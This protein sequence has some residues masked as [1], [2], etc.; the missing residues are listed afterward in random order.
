LVG[1]L[2]YGCP[3]IGTSSINWAQLSKLFTC[4]WKQ[5]L[6]RRVLIEIMTMDNVQEEVHF[7]NTPSSQSLRFK[8]IFSWST[9]IVDPK[10]N[11]LNEMKEIERKH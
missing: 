6:K 11:S 1:W 9:Y 4:G 3:E 2:N 7:N 10:L 5:S 8:D